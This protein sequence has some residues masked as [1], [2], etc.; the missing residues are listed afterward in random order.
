MSADAAT[1]AAGLS[2]AKRA[3][4]E[5][6]LKGRPAGEPPKASIPRRDAGS[7]AP[8]SFAQQR[9]WFIHQIDP[10]SAAYNVPTA[11]RLRGALD[12]DALRRALAEVARRHEVLRTRFE[13]REDGPVA[14]VDPE[15][16]IQLLSAELS[17]RP[18]AER[19]SEAARIAA[20]EAV[21]PFDLAR[22]PL[23]RARLLRF[24]PDDHVLLLTMHHIVSD[25]WS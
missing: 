8:L 10:G 14:V 13:T 25:G 7:P 16:G 22:G 23:V 5:K 2:P 18:E 4:L 9:L 3:L 19:E 20:E 15:G 21:A 6:R 12:A 24:G 11:L 17:A 1:R